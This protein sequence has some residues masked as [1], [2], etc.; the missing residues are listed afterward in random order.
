L[1]R[2]KSLPESD[3]SVSAVDTL[4]ARA[5]ELK[6]QM[7]ANEST[8]VAQKASV[9]ALNHELEAAAADIAR[10]KENLS[11]TTITS[12]IDGIITRVNAKVG[13]VVVMG[14]M[15][16]QGTVILEVADL[17]VMQVDAQVDESNI[18]SV[19]EGQKAKVSIS[20]YPD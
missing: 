17:S 9:L 5:G 15:N 3:M 13:E 19:R 2:Q 14:T 6:A 11:Y 10:A 7:A 20:A 8:V 12:P 16:N 1:A 18:A 4:A